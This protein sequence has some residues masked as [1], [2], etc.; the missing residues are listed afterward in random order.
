MTPAQHL[1]KWSALPEIEFTGIYS[2]NRGWFEI[3]AHSVSKVR[4][5]PKCQ[6]ESRSVY[7]HRWVCILDSPIRDRRVRLRIRKK[8]Y[9]CRK[10]KKPFTELL[11]GIYSQDRTTDRFRRSI[12]YF[13]DR[14]QN[15]VQ[16]AL[17][18]GCSRSTVH[19]NLYA[20]LKRELKRHL[21]YAWPPKVG[22]D[23]NRFGK[24]KGRYQGIDYNTIVV[25]ITHHRIYRVC[26]SKNASKVFEQLKEIPGA[27][28]VLDVAMDLSEG[29]RSLSRALFPNAKITADKFHVLKLLVPAIN[30]LRKKIAGDRRRN[31]IGRLLLR[32][33]NK[34]SFPERSMI[35]RF[36]DP[37]EEL[38]TLYEFKE[39]IHGLYRTRGKERAA[40][41]LN[42]ILEDLKSHQSYDL[43]RLRYTLSRWKNEILNYFDS[44]LTNAMTEGFN[45]KAKLVRK[46]GYGYKSRENYKHRLLNACF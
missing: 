5:C 33:R 39:R 34:L 27:E 16:V 23:E 18:H 2:R 20:Y 21:N 42:H 32:S 19:R 7:D 1:S 26:E 17:H 38:R 12:L 46:M 29:Y 15:L 8:R 40:N 9:N 22:I 25:D 10:C 37:H 14:F 36:L 3:T 45:N 43:K 4:F 24:A 6:T 31:P 28:N 41:A 11:H 44:G 35:N 30:R 13:G